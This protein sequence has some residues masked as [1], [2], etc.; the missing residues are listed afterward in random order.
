M[1]YLPPPLPIIYTVVLLSKMNWHFM[2]WC[3]KFIHFSLWI[4]N[5]LCHG[6]F[7]QLHY[8]QVSLK[9]GLQEESFYQFMNL[10]LS[11][12]DKKKTFLLPL[13][14]IIMQKYV[15]ITKL[16]KRLHLIFVSNEALEACI[17]I[18]WRWKIVDNLTYF[19]AVVLLITVCDDDDGKLATWLTSPDV[20]QL[21]LYIHFITLQSVK[22]TTWLCELFT[23]SVTCGPC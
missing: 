11:I 1:Q 19:V 16:H 5:L 22:I 15:V 3:R 21:W 20:H 18:T 10:Y 6:T 12:S 7:Y 4:D 2:M 8:Q 13:I 14:L 9:W 23:H 17:L